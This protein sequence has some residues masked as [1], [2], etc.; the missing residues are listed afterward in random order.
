[1]QVV[2]TSLIV[3]AAV[4]YA[5]WRVYQALRPDGDPC[6]HCE[7]KKNCKKFCQYKEK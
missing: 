6:Q 5:T 4:G 3:I 7:L 1:M 2:I